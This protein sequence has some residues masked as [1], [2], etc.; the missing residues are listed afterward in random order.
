MIPDDTLHYWGDRFVA[1][2][3]VE[4]MTFEQFLALSP[5]LRERRIAH[6]EIARGVRRQAE[7]E[8]PDAALHDRR[9]IDPMH[10]G[11]RRFRRRLLT[12]LRHRFE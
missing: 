5:P 1:A 2:R 3:L 4:V 6:M 12:R 8:L 7:R 10:H 11:K 9:W